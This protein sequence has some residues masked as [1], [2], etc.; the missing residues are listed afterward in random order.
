MKWT[1][2]IVP[3][4]LREYAGLRFPIQDPRI[5]AVHQSFTMAN[6]CMSSPRTPFGSLS[7]NGLLINDQTMETLYQSDYG[8]ITQPYRMGRYPTLERYIGSIITHRM[9]NAQKL[10]ALSQSLQWELP[11]RYPKV[12]V[13]LYGE[14]DQDTLLKGG[15]HCTCRARLLCAIAQ[16]IGFHAR[17]AMMWAWI[18]FEK[19][20]T[21]L[22]GG[23]TVAE[24]CVDGHWGFFD[25]SHGSYCFDGERFYSIAEIRQTPERWTRMPKHVTD[26]MRIVPY[27]HDL[28]GMNDYEYYWYKNFNPLCPTQISR[29]DVNVDYEIKWTWATEEFRRRQAM[30]FELHKKLLLDLA[31]KDQYTDDIYK[32]GLVAFRDHFGITQWGLE[33]QAE[34]YSAAGV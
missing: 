7:R 31:D 9:S 2:Q 8:H 1:T 11:Q 34:N 14:D 16:M 6:E 26:V 4:H 22:L 21:R 12:P 32:L 17:P 25:P 18:D 23:H 19:D 15:G 20:P 30:D 28:G 13:F 3:A 27:Q 10:I 24:V 5:R 29:H 33:S